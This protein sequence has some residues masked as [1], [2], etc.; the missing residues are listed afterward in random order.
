M[1]GTFKLSAL[2]LLQGSLEHAVYKTQFII[3]NLDSIWSLS[4]FWGRHHGGGGGGGGRMNE[5]GLQ[6][7]QHN[8][9]AV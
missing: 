3:P 2:P 4:L 6:V 8:Q 7:S 5:L 9:G 1:V